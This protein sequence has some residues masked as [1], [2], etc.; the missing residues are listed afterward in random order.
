MSRKPPL[1]RID[2]RSLIGSGALASLLAASGVAADAAP[3][4]GG[5]LRMAVPGFG[6]LAGILNDALGETLTALGPTGALHPGLASAW[7]GSDG[8]AAWRFALAERVF[9]D[10]TPLT[11]DHVAAVLQGRVAG[12]RRIEVRDAAA[13]RFLLD[14]PDPDFPFALADPAHAILTGESGLTG[15]GA[16]RAV[17][18][19]RE[20]GLRL[21]RVEGRGRAWFDGLEILHVRKPDA[22][23]EALISG[24]VDLALDLDAEAQ[25]ALLRQRR[26]GMTAVS[27]HAPLRVVAA[28]GAP[29]CAQ[30]LARGEVPAAAA[31]RPLSLSLAPEAAEF[32]GAGALVS[33]L[34]R[35]ADDAGLT[36]APGPAESDLRIAA[37]APEAG[38]KMQLG[39][40]VDLGFVAP[41][42]AR[43]IAGRWF[44]T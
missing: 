6:V 44:F 17:T 27:H 15:T 36:L 35:A 29:D 39:H 30:C 12:V 1:R 21:A 43:R 7:Q 42:D 23:L 13:V 40:S 41:P 14:R 31:S 34:V 10:G 24:R 32:A 9:H 2:R 11:A 20:A 22:R 8:G 33:A 16:F 3:R 18:T 28:E 38:A 4:P 37:G 19:E 26:L 5:V 25:K